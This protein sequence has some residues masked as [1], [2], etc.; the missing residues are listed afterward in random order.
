VLVVTNLPWG[1]LALVVGPG[2]VTDARGQAAEQVAAVAV[3]TPVVRLL[4]VQGGSPVAGAV[5]SIPVILA[6]LTNKAQVLMAA[7]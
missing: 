1:P 6:M 7:S 5:Q 2:L 3:L 4:G